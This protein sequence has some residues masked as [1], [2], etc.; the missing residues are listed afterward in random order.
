MFTIQK[1]R[2]RLHKFIN[3]ISIPFYLRSLCPPLCFTPLLVATTWSLPT[4]DLTT[5][6]GPVR[7]TAVPAWHEA[8]IGLVLGLMSSRL[9]ARLRANLRTAPDPAAAA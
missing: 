6:L 3:S 7:G 8:P 4:P 1:Y 5:S 9:L 2:I